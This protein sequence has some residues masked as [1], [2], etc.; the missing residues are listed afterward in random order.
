LI[1]APNLS[2]N[3]NKKIFGEIERNLKTSE[4]WFSRTK[5]W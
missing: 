3:E 2:N 5:T 4:K 1:V